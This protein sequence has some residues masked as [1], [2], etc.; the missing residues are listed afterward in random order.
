MKITRVFELIIATTFVFFFAILF[1]PL[2]E[3]QLGYQILFSNYRL[4]IAYFAP[5]IACLIPFLKKKV[6]SVELISMILYLTSAIILIKEV[7]V[8]LSR[9][10]FVI[11]D[12]VLQIVD[13]VLLLYILNSANEYSVRDIVESAMLV[14]LAVGLDLPGLKFKIGANGGSISF[15]MVPLFVLALRLGTL[16]GFIASAIVYGSITCLLDADGGGLNAYIF[17]YFLGYGSI[18]IIGFFRYFILKK[19]GKYSLTGFLFLILGV[20]LSIAGRLTA[21]TISGMVFWETP[22]VESLIYNALYILPSGGFCLAA[23]LLLYKP[24]MIVNNR[25]PN[26]TTI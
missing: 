23:L 6:H 2:F 3:N 8:S 19:D 24:I 1:C 14:A 26:K 11:V 9:N 17:D 21:S 22:F 16:K 13:I 18:A 4:V 15:T 12:I 25:F 5:I 20:V 10:G 7:D